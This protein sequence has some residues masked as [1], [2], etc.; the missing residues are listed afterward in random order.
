MSSAS[1]ICASFYGGQP[2]PWTIDELR[3]AGALERE[4]GWTPAR[5]WFIAT[6]IEKDEDGKPWRGHLTAVNGI[7]KVHASIDHIEE[8]AQPESCCPKYGTP[9]S[10]P[11]QD[12][13]HDECARTRLQLVAD[14]QRPFLELIE[15][16]QRR[17]IPGPKL[18]EFVMGERSKVTGARPAGLGLVREAVRAARREVANLPPERGRPAPTRSPGKAKPFTGAELTDEQLAE[19][20]REDRAR[21]RREGLEA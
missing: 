4:K 2:R 9:P 19:L 14:A 20:E 5:A 7:A 1:E 18:F 3:A 17:G 16:A 13:G 8:R 15:E 10:T 6:W 11:E 12:A 21:R